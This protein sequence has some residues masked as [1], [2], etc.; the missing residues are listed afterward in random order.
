MPIPQVAV[1]V[2]GKYCY[3]L[4]SANPH[5]GSRDFEAPVIVDVALVGRTKVSG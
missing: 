1:D 3:S 2:V 4:K 5:Q